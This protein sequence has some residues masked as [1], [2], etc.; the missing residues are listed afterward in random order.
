MLLSDGLFFDNALDADGSDGV[1]PAG[2]ALDALI[3]LVRG[4]TAPEP[5]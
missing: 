4:A 1:V 5:D 2:A 3:A